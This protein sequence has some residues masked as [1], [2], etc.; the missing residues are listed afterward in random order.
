[1]T[2]IISTGVMQGRRAALTTAAGATLGNAVLLA[3]IASALGWVHAH[4]DLLFEALRW[5]GAAYLV[6][7]G[8][9]AWRHA[10]EG[11]ARLME[12]G[13]ARFARG[14]LVALSNPK[15]IVFFTAF[16][17]QFLDPR[18]P[19]GPQLIAMCVATVV[20]AG[21]SDCAW[22]VAAG[23]GRAWFMK[24]SAP[25]CSAAFPE[26]CSSAAACG[27][28]WPDGR[29]DGV[30]R[31]AAQAAGSSAMT[32]LTTIVSVA[33]ASFAASFVEAVE[34]LTIV[35]AV[36]LA[37]GWRPALTGAAAAL[38]A[39]ALIVA[40]LGPLLGAI[41]IRALQF[42]V[43]VLLLM[44]GLRWLRKAILRAI[45]VVALHDED[46]A[47][48]RET[49]ELTAAERRQAQGMDWIAGVTAFKAVLLEGIEVVFIVIAVGAAR[50]LLGL[51]SAG[52]LAACVLVTGIG[53]AIHRPL[54]R[55]PENALKFAV[56][57]MLSA[58]GLFWTG[59][60]LGVDWPG[61]DGAILAFA[62]LFLG[63]AAALVVTSQAAIG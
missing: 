47:F 63:V 33:G 50:G 1:M 23:M 54:S 19:A 15:T 3:A 20:L 16:L 26:P 24:P 13:R 30:A 12:T 41:P 2:L 35:L 5:T 48:Q 10:G 29:I 21:V 44:F 32:N 60:S 45:G 22:A 52:A 28:R 55:V 11:D 36:G 18:L 37:R 7:L 58:F 59:E 49:R 61:G 62:A 34:A 53:V 42:I 17:P 27:F 46:A 25:S 56:G 9:Q 8:V 39:L 57:V 51:A 31:P 43:G 4:A 38:A 14:I 6:W 40:A